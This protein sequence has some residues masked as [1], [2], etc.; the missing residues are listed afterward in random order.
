M[1]VS[2]LT[3]RTRPVPRTPGAGGDDPGFKVDL[4]ADLRAAVGGLVRELR[5]A[6][7]EPAKPQAGQLQLELP[8]APPVDLEAVRE[9]VRDALRVELDQRDETLREA[10]KDVAV[11]VASIPTP[12]P[13]SLERPRTVYRLDVKRN[14]KS[15]V[16]EIAAAP[17]DRNAPA[18]TFIVHRDY[19]DLVSWLE[20]KAS[21]PRKAEG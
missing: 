16:T 17:A 5:N 2:M 14:F 9:Q 1:G 21:L 15:L 10:I 8:E 19:N 20:V 18:Y 4:R 7:T 12:E 6:L 13:V 3:G 11:A